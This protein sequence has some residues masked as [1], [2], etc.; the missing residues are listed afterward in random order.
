M[1]LYLPSFSWGLALALAFDPLNLHSARSFSLNSFQNPNT[2][3]GAPHL[4]SDSTSTTSLKAIRVD[5]VAGSTRAETSIIARG[6]SVEPLKTVENVNWAQVKNLFGLDREQSSGLKKIAGKYFGKNPDDAFLGTKTKWGDFSQIYGWTPVT[7]VSEPL[8]AKITGYKNINQLTSTR[9]F[10]NDS[11]REA[12]FHASGSQTL[13]NTA[14]TNWSNT[15]SITTKTEVGIDIEIFKVTTDITFSNAWSKGGSKSETFAIG[16]DAGVTFTLK[17]GETAM[18]HL[19][20][21]QLQVKAQVK[22]RQRLKGSVT[23]NYGSPYKGHHF[24]AL[25]A[26]ELV[27]TAKKSN[28]VEVYQDVV[29]QGFSNGSVTVSSGGDKKMLATNSAKLW[30]K[31]KNKASFLVQ[32]VTDPYKEGDDFPG[33]VTDQMYHQLMKEAGRIDVEEEDSSM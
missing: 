32:S 19:T 18:V 2:R 4:S 22:Y 11:D 21:D 1:V 14:E 26:A 12:I 16:T 23:V 10:T 15:D 29:L 17:P 9:V 20:A 30:D 31:K 25:S 13:T 28:S 33:Y 27:K 7:L 5:M 8:S 6:S 24:W 3:K